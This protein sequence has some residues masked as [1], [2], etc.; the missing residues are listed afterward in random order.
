[1]CAAVDRSD[2]E[3]HLKRYTMYDASQDAKSGIPLTAALLIPEFAS[4]PLYPRILQI[5]IDAGTERLTADRFLQL[6]ALMSSSMPTA[7]K[8]QCML[9]TPI[10]YTFALFADIFSS[11]VFCVELCCLFIYCC[12]LDK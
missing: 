2:I 6:C 10:M 5:F 4:N 3:R 8:K 11:C 1:M 7:A 12:S 9:L